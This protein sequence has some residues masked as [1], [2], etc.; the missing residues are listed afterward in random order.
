[1]LVLTTDTIPDGFHVK[2]LH[3]TI[4]AI[5]RIA[6]Q[7][8][9]IIDSLLKRSP[10]TVDDGLVELIN[11]AGKIKGVNCIFGI[12]VTSTFAQFKNGSFI[13]YTYYATVAE[14]DNQ[15]T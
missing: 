15:L 12:R 7:Q 9:N 10:G 5:T 14:I 4:S 6:I 11:N 13:Y 3:G 2:H 1:M 8:Q